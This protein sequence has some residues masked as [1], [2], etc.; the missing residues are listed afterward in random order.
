MPCQSFLTLKNIYVTCIISY[1]SYKFSSR[2]KFNSLLQKLE[3]L[4][5]NVNRP[6]LHEHLTLLCDSPVVSVNIS[7][8]KRGDDTPKWFWNQKVEGIYCFDD[9]KCI[10]VK[11]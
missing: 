5:T 6:H 2:T 11:I 9:N 3:R 4:F 1:F 10:H 7:I 8:D